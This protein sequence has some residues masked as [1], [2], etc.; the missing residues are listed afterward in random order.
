MKSITCAESKK[1][2][3]HIWFIVDSLSKTLTVF[4]PIMECVIIS[5]FQTKGN[6][7]DS[8]S[9]NWKY[10]LINIGRVKNN[11]SINRLE[12]MSRIKA[13][14]QLLKIKTTINPI[15]TITPRFIQKI[16][17]KKKKLNKFN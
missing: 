17:D 13:P 1:C 4:E 8:L 15:R 3:F 11:L 2:L 10:Y 7:I 12:V 14:D 6:F 16:I 5:D 9:S